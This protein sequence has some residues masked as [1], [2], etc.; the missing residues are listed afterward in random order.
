MVAVLDAAVVG[1]GIAVVVVVASNTAA[2]V[3][4]VLE[5][6]LAAVAVELGYSL[7]VEA[8][9]WVA[10]LDGSSC[11]VDLLVVLAMGHMALVASQ[12]GDMTMAVA[13]FVVVG[14]DDGGGVMAL[15]EEVAADLT[16]SR[17]RRSDKVVVE[18][19]K[20]VDEWRSSRWRPWCVD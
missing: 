7:V 20:R 5:H 6:S 17:N 15:L 3:A 11:V 19:G 1:V 14:G 12:L 4:V 8:H 13:L 18:L 16:G 9:R 2:V 10:A